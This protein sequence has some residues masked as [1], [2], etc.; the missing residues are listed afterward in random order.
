MKIYRV[1]VFLLLL[2]WLV[3][4]SGMALFAQEPAFLSN[5]LVAYYPFN[6]NANDESGNVANGSVTGATLTTDRFGVSNRAY[7][8]G[9]TTAYITV[10]RDG[11]FFT[12]DFTVSVVLPGF[13]GDFSLGKIG[14]TTMTAPKNAGKPG[15]GRFD[16]KAARAGARRSPPCSF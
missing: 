11:S 2:H 12:K 6:G 8:F 16:R 7:L 5:G 3:S 10:P 13:P 9:R 1:P 4:F 14:V 15:C